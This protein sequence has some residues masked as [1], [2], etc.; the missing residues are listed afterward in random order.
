MRPDL[1]LTWRPLDIPVD[2]RILTGLLK[3]NIKKVIYNPETDRRRRVNF[4]SATFTLALSL[5]P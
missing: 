2:K 5:V 4:S 1:P 3:L